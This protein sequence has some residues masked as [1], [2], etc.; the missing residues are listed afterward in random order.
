MT[1]VE[2]ERVLK[3]SQTLL[4]VVIPGVNHPAIGLEVSA[5]DTPNASSRC[6]NQWEALKATPPSG[7]PAQDVDCAILSHL[8]VLLLGEG[9]PQQPHMTNRICPYLHQHSRTQVLV[10]VPP[11]TGAAGAAAGTQDALIEPVL[12]GVGDHSQVTPETHDKALF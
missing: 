5:I 2:R 3:L 9:L 4:C 1:T 11:V 8:S 10:P 7:I 6:C 12:H